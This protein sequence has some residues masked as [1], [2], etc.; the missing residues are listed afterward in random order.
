MKS[1]PSPAPRRAFTLIELLV[2][3]AIIA[4]LAGL[5]LPA[6]GN[7]KTKA[8][9]R[10]ARLEMTALA[11]AI[12]QYESEYKR[13]PSAKEA[14]QCAAQNADCPDYTYGTSNPDG[15]LL[16]PGLPAVKSYGSPTYQS[17]NAELLAILR[18]PKLAPQ[19][20]SALV[21]LARDRNPRNL[22]LFEAKVVSGTGPGLGTDG[23][24]RDP[25]G[26]PYLITIDMN[27]DDR[28]LDGYYGVLRKGTAPEP[29]VKASV[30]IWS[31]G[32]DGQ[33]TDD[34]NVGPKGGVNKD[35]ILSWE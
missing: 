3:I 29:E 27:D 14:A 2:V 7:A 6:L 28:C 12:Q 22:T 34:S 11:A 25:W 13:M 26:N 18:G 4:I 35:N 21:Q 15:S 32:P 8:K 16:Q 10:V 17:G 24:L 23:V 31:F 5:L 9:V 19:N 30:L 1:I 33:A 20:N